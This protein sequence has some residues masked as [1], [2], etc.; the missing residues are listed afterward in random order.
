[1]KQNLH[2][3][4]KC[5]C[6]TLLGYTYAQ[7]ATAQYSESTSFWEAGITIGPSNFLGDL[8]GNV[9]K[10]TPFL[11]DNNIQ[12]T[13]LTF[14]A[15]ATYHP[16]EYFGVRFAANVGSLEGDDAIIKGKGGLEEA[17]KTRNSNFKSSLV[18]GMI[19]L[20]IF[21][22][23]FL[24]YEPSDIFHKLR[25]YGVIGVGL[26]HFNPKGQDPTSGN[27]VALQPLRTE[28]QGFPEYPER[29]EYKLTQVNIPLGVGVK[30]YLSE[31]VNFGLEI[32]HRKTFTDYI[33]D[34]STDY[35]DPALFYSNMSLPQAQ[36]AQRMANKSIPYGNNT[37]GFTTGMKRGTP[38]NND[39]YY[40]VS[41][42]LG[43]RI[44]NDRY[45]NST[46]CPVSF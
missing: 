35:I 24:E 45:A 15:F 8:G 46:R 41:I 19:G 11:K 2:S 26:F 43:I 27:W 23:A 38:T 4:W 29:K 7:S 13:K 42:K 16:S 25:P 14:G 17:R 39:S 40:S 31:T 32:L 20:E 44:A 28:G 33:D 6:L 12:T 18:E 5:L 22:T 10:G 37:T 9:G 36:L 30:Y 3:V 34:V 1:M 21:P